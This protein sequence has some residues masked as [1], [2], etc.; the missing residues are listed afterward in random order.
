MDN[1]E[2]C[3]T[4]SGFCLIADLNVFGALFLKCRIVT[5]LRLASISVLMLFLANMISFAVNV[6]F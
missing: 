6:L 4:S 5:D 1:K 2:K 3:S